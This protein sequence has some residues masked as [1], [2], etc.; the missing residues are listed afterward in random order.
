MLRYA[1]G[2]GK[3]YNREEKSQQQDL[4]QYSVMLLFLIWYALK[5]Q[6]PIGKD[7]IVRAIGKKML[8]SSY[9]NREIYRVMQKLLKVNQHLLSS[10]KKL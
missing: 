6:E 5:L 10:G 8:S 3:N 2:L 1:K 4:E 7:R 9:Q